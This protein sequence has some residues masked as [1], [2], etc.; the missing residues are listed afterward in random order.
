MRFIKRST[1]SH[2]RVSLILLDWGVRESF[3]LLHYLKDQTVARE[4]FEVILI[5]YYGAVSAAARK[6]ESEI[7]TW[8]LLEMPADCYYHKHLMYNAGV[9]LGKGGLLLFRDCDAMG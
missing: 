6:F 8:M 1:R 7:D 5:E 3:H 2:P 9:V 4:D